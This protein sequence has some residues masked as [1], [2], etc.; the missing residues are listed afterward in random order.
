MVNKD[1][2]SK[3][4]K[5]SARILLYLPFCCKIVE[6]IKNYFDPHELTDTLPNTKS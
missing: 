4:P 2:Y 6:K 1:E 5:R 3:V